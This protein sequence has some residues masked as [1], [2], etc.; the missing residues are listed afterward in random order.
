MN[1]NR[2]VVVGHGV[3]LAHWGPCFCACP[4][5]QANRSLN[6]MS[7]GWSGYY[8]VTCLRSSKKGPGSARHTS[9]RLTKKGL[10]SCLFQDMPWPGGTGGVKIRFSQ[11]MS[12]SEAFRCVCLF[13][14]FSKLS[15]P[16]VVAIRS[17]QR[18]KVQAAHA[19]CPTRCSPV[20]K[21][22]SWRI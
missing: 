16:L 1:V 6:S 20:R 22:P 13:L 19:V 11:K 14:Q 21:S 10:H 9:P 5:P 18:L 3:I 2:S 8:P 15:G 12:L 7:H 17:R 4:F